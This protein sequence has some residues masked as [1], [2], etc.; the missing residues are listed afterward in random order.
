VYAAIV[1]KEEGA[2]NLRVVGGPLK[3]WEELERRG[4]GGN[5]QIQYSCMTLAKFFLN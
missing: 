5:V 1:I 4:K 3:K 2:N